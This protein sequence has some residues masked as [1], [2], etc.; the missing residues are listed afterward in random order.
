MSGKLGGAALAVLAL[1]ACPWGIAQDGAQRSE[2][3]IK[4]T[5]KAERPD[6]DGKQSIQVTLAINKGW[7]IYANPV[8][9]EDL[10]S[11]ATAVTVKPKPASV[12]ISYPKGEEKKDKIVGDYRVY[13]EQVT[14]PIQIRRAAGDTGA[15][16]LEVRVNACNVKGFCLP[17]GTLKI[18]VQ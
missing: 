17:P 12:E 3:Q 16:E 9:N 1:A 14:I 2:S 18:T 8:G 7:Y 6:K 13:K 10:A 15:L 4:A 11:N 5:V